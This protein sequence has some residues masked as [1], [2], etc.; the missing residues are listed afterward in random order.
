M[1]EDAAYCIGCYTV[2]GADVS[3]EM[4]GNMGVVTKY[5]MVVRG[6]ID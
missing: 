5:K 2:G 4:S 1:M 6:V 3:I